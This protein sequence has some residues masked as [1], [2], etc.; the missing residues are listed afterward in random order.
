[1]LDKYVKNKI[2]KETL[3]WIFTFLSAFLIVLLVQ[4][5]V[6]K[7]ATVNGVSME[8]TLHH[9]ENV[10]IQRFSYFFSEPNYNDII[11]FPYKMDTKQHFIKRIIGKPNDII[12][13]KDQK[14]YLN[15]EEVQDIFESEYITAF[16][17]IEFP[18]TIPKDCYFVL[19][20]NRNRSK[21]S[22]YSEVGLI[23]KKDILGKI[24][25]R[26]WPLNKFGIIK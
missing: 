19:G 21:D 1:M 16:G 14:F 23:N 17:D 18:I 13:F 5:F 7:N 12:D 6:F 10:I 2:L 26:I 15:G 4:R 11:A 22:R 24:S 20:D 9:N 25:L 8:P 3:S